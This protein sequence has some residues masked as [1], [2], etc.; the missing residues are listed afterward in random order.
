M[1]TEKDLQE[2]I[3]E[4]QGERNPNSQTCIKLAAF[5]T[6]KDHLY[7]QDIERPEPAYSFANGTDID[8]PT[9][10]YEGDSEFFQQAYGKPQDEICAIVDE[11]MTTL[12]I[13]NP[14]LYAGVMRRV[15]E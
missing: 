9:I 13:V 14:A 11:L 6:I 12:Q 7:P 8:V 3:A 1:I 10:E 4:C 15:A 5:Y 2:A